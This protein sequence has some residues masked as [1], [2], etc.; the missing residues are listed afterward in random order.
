MGR[1]G[2]E[3]VTSSVSGMPIPFDPVA[4]GRVTAAKR[5]STVMARRAR[6]DDAWRRRHLV[7]HWLPRTAF[8]RGERYLMAPHR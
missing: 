5:G 6:A 8:S 2:F 4:H 7:S 1:T 3:P